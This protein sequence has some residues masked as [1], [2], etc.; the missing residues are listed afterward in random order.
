MTSRA[1]RTASA[2]SPIRTGIIG[3]GLAG[4]VFHA[5]LISSNP[6][7]SLDLISTGNAARQEQAAGL[8]PATTVVATPGEL[9]ARAGDLDL[10]VLAS[11]AHSH[12]EQGLSALH[13]GVAVVIDKPFAPTAHDAEILI[14]AARAAGRPLTV[15]QNRRWDGD[16]LTVEKLI[17]AKALGTIERFESSYEVWSPKRAARWQD[18]TTSANGAG[19]AFDLGS[20]V[21]DQALRLFG[22][23]REVYAETSAVREGAVSEDDLFVALRHESGVKSHITLSRVAALS[24]PRFRVLGTEGAYLV[25][26]IDGQEDALKAGV[27]PTDGN[28]GITDSSQWGT[29]RS[30][31]ESA[32][33]TMPTERGDYPAFYAGVAAA[34]RGEAPMPVDPWDSLEVVRVIERIHD[35]GRDRRNRTR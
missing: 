23:V 19:V 14:E 5:P 8:Y 1:N 24:A 32:I 35:H 25:D 29:L 10:I 13:A 27:L 21:I 7:F 34:I 31:P 28:Y 16:F 18:T 22:P 12:R 30:G 3:F 11:P 17:T 26:G 20:H 15:F 4:R 2:S 6:D 9:I 33:T